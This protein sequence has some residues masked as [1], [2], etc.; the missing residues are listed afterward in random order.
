MHRGYKHKALRIL[1]NKNRHA[2]KREHLINKMCWHTI[3]YTVFSYV[4]YTAAVMLFQLDQK[5]C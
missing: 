1:N 4:L 2:Q 5:A 3:L